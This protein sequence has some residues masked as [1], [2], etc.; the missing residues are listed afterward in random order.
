MK[1]D[2]GQM[3][4]IEKFFNRRQS[5]LDLLNSKKISMRGCE[6]AEKTGMSAKDIYKVLNRMDG[7]GEVKKS[8]LYFQAI[9]TDAVLLKRKRPEKREAKRIVIEPAI[10]I[11]GASRVYRFGDRK[12]RPTDIHRGE[13]G[14]VAYLMDLA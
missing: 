10:R 14:R 2:S 6:I 12:A 1:D 4:R 13:R 3:T 8:G 9:R 7:F 5:I 11:N